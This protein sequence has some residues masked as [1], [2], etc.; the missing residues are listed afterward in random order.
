ML[1]STLAALTSFAV[2][3]STNRAQSPISFAARAAANYLTAKQLHE[4]VQTNSTFAWQFARACFDR[5]EFSTNDTERATL[6]LQGIAAC[7]EI[8]AREFTNAAAH[9][10]LGMNLG[11]LARTKM[12]GALP[13]VDEMEAEFKTAKLYDSAF[14]HAGPD[15]CLG[16]LYLDAPT[17]GSVGSR[18]KARQHLELA[19][20]A[21]PEYP[22][23]YLNLTEAFLRWRDVAAARTHF[24]QLEALLPAARTNLTGD[25]WAASWSDW[26]RRIKKAGKQLEQP[27]KP[28]GHR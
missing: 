23:N 15:R 28:A 9:Y 20:K 17:L 2:N 16:L 7:R 19:A 27:P 4:S 10:Y 6:A 8:L 26:D 24:K 22:E 21:A 12:L 18:R 11:Q 25:A 1:I 14:D 3:E 13:I 5:A